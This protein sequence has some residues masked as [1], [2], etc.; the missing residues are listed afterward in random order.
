M[1]DEVASLEEEE[2]ALCKDD[3]FGMAFDL[4]L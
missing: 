2:L 3:D 1:A 4:E